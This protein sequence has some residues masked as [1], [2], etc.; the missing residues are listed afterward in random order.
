MFKSRFI[1]ILLC[2]AIGYKGR[3]Q[4]SPT[5]PYRPPSA[6]KIEWQRLHLQLS[7]TY[8]TVVK[9]NQVD[10]DSSLLYVSH[11]LGLSRIA[12]L[13]EGINEKDLFVA[14][15]DEKN[16]HKAIDLLMRL[17]GKK[18]LEL[19]MLLGAYYAFQPNGYHQ[20]KDSVEYFLKMAIDESKTLG[21][22]RL[23]RIAL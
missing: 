19:L 17:T 16:P 5:P 10:F 1:W 18:H 22:K 6:Y 21:E 13:A 23:G 8:F 7:S 20:Y 14:W 2:V 12:V 15:V 3:S 11:S 4:S 9:E